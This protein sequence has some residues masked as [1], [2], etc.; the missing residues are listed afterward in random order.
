MFHR[1]TM[2]CAATDRCG[3]GGSGPMVE[4]MAVRA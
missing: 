4:N 3:C 2:F 1:C